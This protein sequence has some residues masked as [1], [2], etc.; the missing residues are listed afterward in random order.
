VLFE[1]VFGPKFANHQTNQALVDHNINE[2][3]PR[4][5]AYLERYVAELKDVDSSGF[6]VGKTLSIADITVASI[7][8][9]WTFAGQRV[10]RA[11]YPKLEAHLRRM[12][13]RPSFKKALTEEKPIA[14][15]IGDLDLWAV[16]VAEAA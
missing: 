11:K 13:R 6:L 2:V 14:L 12:L 7:L 8:V 3:V 4:K 10:D 15:D 16:E 5:L 9:H 1:T